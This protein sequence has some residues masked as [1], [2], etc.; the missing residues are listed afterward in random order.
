MQSKFKYTIHHAYNS[1]NFPSAPIWFLYNM[2]SI[3][4]DLLEL[5]VHRNIVNVQLF[6][7][8][9]TDYRNKLNDIG[10]YWKTFYNEENIILISTLLFF[11]NF[12]IKF[13]I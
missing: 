8:A 7:S 6:G 5:E 4:N 1:F 11:I 10:L 3:Y 13:F 2:Y 12:C 9:L